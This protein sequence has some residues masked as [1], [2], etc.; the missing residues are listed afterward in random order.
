MARR[1]G[2]GGASPVDSDLGVGA[3]A[4]EVQHGERGLVEQT[5]APQGGPQGPGGPPQGQ[6]P[7]QPPQ[8]GAGM[9]LFAPSGHPG[10]PIQAG[11][12][13]GPGGQGGQMLENDPDDL[14]RAIY[15]AYPHD[16]IRALLEAREF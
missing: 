10:E 3:L 1:R 7:A 11:I 4:G 13:G 12:P 8:G 16:D 15:Q 5:A 14:L 6:P 2:R 9:D